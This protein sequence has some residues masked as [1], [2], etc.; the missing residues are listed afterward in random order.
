MPDS[1]GAN[2]QLQQLHSR[3]GIEY[4]LVACRSNAEDFVKPYAYFSSELVPNFFDSSMK[5]SVHDF[6]VQFE[7]YVMSGVKG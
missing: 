7:A 4:M 6:A 2:S 1:P 3:T 5:R